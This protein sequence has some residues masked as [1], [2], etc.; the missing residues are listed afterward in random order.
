MKLI[1]F[2]VPSYNSQNYLAKCVESL[3]V[4]GEDVEILIVNDGSKDDTAKIADEY[5]AKYPT[6]VRAIHKENGG[7][8]SG[9]NRGLAEATGLYYKVVDSDDWVDKDAYLQLLATMKDHLAKGT[10][11]DL[12]ITNF[13]YEHV[14]DNTQH[15]SSYR[16]KYPVGKVFTWK[17]TK[18]LKLWNMILMHSVIYKTEKARKSGVNLPE[19]TF[20]VDNLFAFQP[21][22]HMEK[23]FYLDIDFYRYYIGRVDQSVTMEN[24]VKRYDQQIRVM[25]C[26][27]SAYTYDELKA[28]NKPL[29]KLMYHD[30][31]NVMLNTAF[32]TTAKDSP[33]R[34]ELYKKMWKDLKA[35][36][37]K[38]YYKMKYRTGVAI[39]NPCP[40]KLK[41]AITTW[42]YKFL[43]KHV[44]LGA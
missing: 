40:W 42:C 7:H 18:C 31:N 27:M 36:D 35:R 4:G 43:C 38:L 33:E 13:V 1:S 3:L 26:M 10:D 8:G 20:Y 15:V 24:L 19:H 39:L 30:L 12:Y 16:G 5:Q 21:L 6:I 29:R 11:I 37:Q 34:R 25:N 9:V 44:K 2:A 14:D 41:G 17:E 32:F 22:P 28:M 23:I